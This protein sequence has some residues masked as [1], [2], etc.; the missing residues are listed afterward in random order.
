MAEPIRASQG[1]LCVHPRSTLRFS[2]KS[3][4]NLSY[5]WF[6]EAFQVVRSTGSLRS[7]RSACVRRG[8]VTY[9]S[10]LPDGFA[11]LHAGHPTTPKVQC[12]AKGYRA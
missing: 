3:P 7:E 2:L 10:L 6:I 11:P 5:S 9:S 8:C 1:F 12:P 4:K